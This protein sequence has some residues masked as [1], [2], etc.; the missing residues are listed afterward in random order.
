MHV[1]HLVAD[2]LHAADDVDAVNPELIRF[3]LEGRAAE[4]DVRETSID[5]A[6]AR[7][8]CRIRREAAEGVKVVRV[9]AV[10]QARAVHAVWEAVRAERSSVAV[11]AP[12][13]T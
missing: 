9:R 3:Q 11:R 13:L 8:G 1:D 4:V 6:N 5:G 7:G 2:D 10:R 12:R